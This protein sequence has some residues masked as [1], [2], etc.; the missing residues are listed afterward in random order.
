MNLCRKKEHKMYD[1]KRIYLNSS[2]GVG[3]E[4][5]GSLEIETLGSL[6][7]LE[8]P[9]NIQQMHFRYELNA[10]HFEVSSLV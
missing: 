9:L 1:E 6:Y 8:Y 10:F 3:L 2:S 5:F 4:G 7:I